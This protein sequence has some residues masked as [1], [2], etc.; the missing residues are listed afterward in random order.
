M[1]KSS[2]PAPDYKGAAEA[3]AD[4]N[5]LSNI[6]TTNANRPTMTTPW[7]TSEWTSTDRLDEAAYNRAMEDW[8]ASGGDPK[9]RPS[10]NDYYQRDYTNNVTLSGQQQQALDHQM[11]IQANQSNLAAL[12]QGQVQ[13]TM[14][15]GF[16]GPQSSTYFNGMPSVN[17]SFG[18]FNPTGV[19]AVNQ[20]S[21]NPN[22]YTNG[23]Q[24]V[25]QNFGSSAQGV[26][27]NPNSFTAAAGSTNLNAPSFNTDNTAEGARAAYAASTELLK[28]QWNQDNSALDSKLRMQ[29]LTPG[30][31]A[32][33]NAMQ[34]Q[35]RVQAQQQ[36]QLANQ[37]VVT[38]NDMAN[39]NY[40]SALAGFNAGNSAQNQAYSQ[41]LS[42][43]GATN[44][45]LGQQ[46]GQDATAYGLSND[47]RTQALQNQLA[48]YQAAISG[49]QAGNEAQQQAYN[50]A[51]ASYGANQS[52]QQAGN[53]AQAQA[54]EQAA[55]R[56]QL[57]YSSALQNYLQPLNNM[58]AVLNGQQVQSPTFNNF[59]QSAFT[60]GADYSGAA[61]A[62]GQWNSAQAAQNNAATGSTLGTLGSLAA[63]FMMS[64]IRLKKNI[65]R[66]GTTPAGIPWYSWDWLDGSGSSRGV[67][68]QEV[69]LIVPGAVQKAA[70]DFFMVDYAQVA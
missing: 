13:S 17:T 49:Q 9:K 25:N 46:F 33:N 58:N 34:N 61:S 31:E 64:D 53:A 15:G 23:V 39:Q 45:A 1:G 35:Q 69:A 24:G 47:A 66:V 26:Q 65:K 60:P 67:L 21:F 27:T 36:N 7:G 56:Y 3:T 10:Q 42:S 55:N 44:S 63:M 52:A 37:A 8:Q 62:T 29:G 22:S 19:G 48:Q 2:S 16:N 14:A 43:F 5:Q 38:G 6:W 28:D 4:A 18:Q 12:L 57:D 50:Q 51:L 32:Y 30:T 59:V 11:A 70:N 68:A 40:A 54:F 20:Q 41:G